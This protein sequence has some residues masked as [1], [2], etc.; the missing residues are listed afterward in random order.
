MPLQQ[1]PL[2]W[3]P[4]NCTDKIDVTRFRFVSSVLMIQ[5]M[6]LILKFM[7]LFLNDDVSFWS[8]IKNILCL[9]EYIINHKHGI[10]FPFTVS[11]CLNFNGEEQGTMS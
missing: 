6:C 5:N 10:A 11:A 7:K 3:H 4:K 9:M 2:N 8:E 1:S